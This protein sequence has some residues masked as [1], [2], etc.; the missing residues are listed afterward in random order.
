MPDQAFQ[1]SSA[2]FD[3][4]LRNP[5]FMRTRDD[6]RHLWTGQAAQ[7]RGR[8]RGQYA[9][10][11]PAEEWAAC[12]TRGGSPRQE[13]SVYVRA[14]QLLHR[15]ANVHSRCGYRCG[16]HDDHHEHQAGLGHRGAVHRAE[17]VA[18]RVL[19]ESKDV[20]D[21]PRHRRPLQ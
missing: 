3:P 20:Q 15:H 19:S 10:H 18:L 13:K 1:R 17:R 9:C 11:P 12:P 6:R 5:Q 8:G 2:V 14:D 7:G 21:P 16:H 4:R